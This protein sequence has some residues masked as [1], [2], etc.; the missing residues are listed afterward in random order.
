MTAPVHFLLKFFTSEGID[1]IKQIAGTPDKA[2]SLHHVTPH[3][4]CIFLRHDD[5]LIAHPF[6]L[7]SDFLR[8]LH[9]PQVSGQSHLAYGD[10]SD[11]A[12]HTAK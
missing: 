8:I 11:R 2:A 12:Y 4:R 10:C 5:H 3:A 9:R 6:G 7:D 1:G